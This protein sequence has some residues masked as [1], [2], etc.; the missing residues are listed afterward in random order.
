MIDARLLWHI[1]TL[2]SILDEL[3]EEN[4]GSVKSSH[5]TPPKR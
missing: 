3:K 1:E 4:L 2:T 5:P